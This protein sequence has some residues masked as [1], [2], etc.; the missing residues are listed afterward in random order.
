MET[1][2]KWEHFFPSIEETLKLVDGK[3]KV[4]YDRRI[5]GVVRKLS[6][7]S[8]DSEEEFELLTKMPLEGRGCIISKQSESV[9]WR[10]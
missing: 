8:E 6:Q 3:V 7:L 1:Y 9:L 10:G 2:H 4:G 5:R